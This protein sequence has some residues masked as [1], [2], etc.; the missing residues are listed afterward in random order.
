MQFDPAIILH[1]KYDFGHRKISNLISYSFFSQSYDDDSIYKKLEILSNFYSAL[2]KD[3]LNHLIRVSRI[4]SPLTRSDCFL[5][6]L[7]TTSIHN[8]P[9]PKYSIHDI[10]IVFEYEPKYGFMHIRFYGSLRS[11]DYLHNF[12]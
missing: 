8:P 4:N 5:V 10:I 3:S 11:K 7:L 1:P 6:D 2:I 9:Y 12:H